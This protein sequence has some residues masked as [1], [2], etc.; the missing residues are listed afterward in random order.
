MIERSDAAEQGNE[1]MIP[2]IL[3][4]GKFREVRCDR[5]RWVDPKII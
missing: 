2:Y 4:G 5:P 1:F 3:E